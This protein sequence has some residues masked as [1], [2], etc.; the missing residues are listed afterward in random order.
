[1]I[2]NA[3]QSMSGVEDDDRELQVSTVSI[4]PEACAS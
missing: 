3:I 4:D 2:V 1:L